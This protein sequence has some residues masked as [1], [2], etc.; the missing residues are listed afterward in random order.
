MANTCLTISTL[1]M[2]P[3]SNNVYVVDDGKGCFVVDPTC[4]ADRILKKVG[5]RTL[6]A[7]V[8]THGHWDHTGAAKKL[9]D[10]TGAEVI[11]SATEA[12]YID[13]SKSFGGHSGRSVPCPV[14]REVNDGDVVEIGNVTLRVIATPGHTPGGICLLAEPSDTHPGL[15]TLFSGDTLFAGTHGRVDFAESDP[16][17]MKDSLMKLALLPEETV[18][19]PGHESTTTIAR[20]IGWLRFGRR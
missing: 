2:G 15:P 20:E 10:A 4:D 7:I 12:P 11:A 1:V 16:R 18:V 6:D 13:G 8:I 5:D 17:A 3:I 9:R 19:L 14:D